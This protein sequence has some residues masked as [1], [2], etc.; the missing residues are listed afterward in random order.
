MESEEQ[1]WKDG[2]KCSLSSPFISKESGLKPDQMVQNFIEAVN[3]ATGLFKRDSQMS[4][5]AQEM[6]I[7][8]V[9]D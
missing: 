1:L 7:S 2:I 6:E 3:Y 5:V 4:R 9:I 8:D